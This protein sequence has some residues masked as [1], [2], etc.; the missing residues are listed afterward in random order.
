MNRP[1]WAG[2]ARQT[3]RPL[4]P[5]FLAVWGCLAAG[6]SQSGM[7]TLA[8]RAATILI[9]DS[10]P[11]A[12]I[13][14]GSGASQDE[15]D[16][17]R[18]LAEHIRLATGVRL[19]VVEGP[20]ATK[21]VG[22]QILVGLRASP[23]LRERLSKLKPD[24]F[25]IETAPGRLV[26]AGKPPNGTSFAVYRF[27]ENAVG[28]RWLW[29]GENGT[30]IPKTPS[31]AVGPMTVREEPAFLW[32]A[33]GPGG[34]L[35]GPADK[36][37]K[38][39]ELGVSEEH[40]R[41]QKLWEKRNRFGGLRVRSG[42]A[43]GEILPP[44]LYGPKQ[45]ELFALTGGVRE[46]QNFDGKHR[47]Q[48]CTTNPEVV[49]ITAEYCRRFF[50]R[51]PDYDA[52]SISL[53]DGRGFCECER[54]RRLDT[55]EMQEERA[56]PEGN[57]G[58]SSPV[59]TDRVVTF[60]NEVARQLE[61]T[62]PSKKVVMEAYS[63]YSR[64]PVR[65]KPLPNVIIQYT[66]QSVTFWNPKEQARYWAEA[67]KWGGIAPSLGIYE[68]IAQSKIAD[69]PRWFPELIGR[70]VA[71]LYDFGYRYY[72]TQASNGHAASGV[73]YYVLA[74]VL[75]NPSAD[76]KAI[77][78]DYIESGYGK[79]APAVR[80]Y[81]QRM[82]GRWREL[83]VDSAFSMQRVT[84]AQYRSA[85]ALYPADFRAACRR[86]LAEAASLAQGEDRR[87]VQ[88]LADG[89]RY[90]DLTMQAVERT[91]PLLEQGWTLTGKVSA[92]AGADL[93]EF[94]A[95]LAAW[96]ERERFVEEHKNDFVLGYVWVRYNDLQ[97]GFNPLSH[98]REFRR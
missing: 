5:L 57:R 4:L 82:T 62:Q 37:T 86:D 24:G 54:C 6:A 17:A 60:A 21:P 43:F 73:N 65:V 35:W 52:V 69:I 74:R 31:L 85:A 41:A 58:G 84:L 92:P 94:K 36:W 87:R 53:N 2:L 3:P 11:R 98:M 76:V 30:I 18:E 44:A 56:G 80:R 27:L 9:Q 28:V 20:Q 47:K 95:A 64:P 34:A 50:E 93:A 67:E 63:Q 46:W 78:R 96:E 83:Q 22:T 72:E 97:D 16:A 1:H 75:W 7:G 51:N 49:R 77:E 66:F 13:V 91:L 15:R 79:A 14:L 89:F 81:F 70:S 61:R 12:T 42:H 45:P 29:P 10:R 90:L 39:R 19:P 88:F 40:Q 33:L 59:I 38:E 55:G 32:R 48:P 26:L 68:Y 71:R 25:V 23:A 8:G